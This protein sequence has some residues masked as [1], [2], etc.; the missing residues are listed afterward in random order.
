[1]AERPVA[2]PPV[3]LEG[4]MA[5]SIAPFVADLSFDPQTIELV[6]AAFDEACLSLNDMGQPDIVK[7][8]IARRIVEVAQMGERDLD[9]MC[10]RALRSL[11]IP[12]RT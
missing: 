11:G 3:I 1:V 9:R 4:A 12:F 6:G 10:A 2:L 7:E 5:H 8:V